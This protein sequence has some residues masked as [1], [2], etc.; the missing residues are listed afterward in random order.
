MPTYIT[1]VTF[2]NQGMRNIKDVATRIDEV[3]ELLKAMGGTFQAVYL[4]LGAYDN[5]AIIDAPNDEVMAKFALAV[6]ARGNVRTTTLTAFPEAEYRKL[7][8]GLP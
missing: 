1:L 7:V 8:A 2:T 6:G 5:V 4:T 3:K